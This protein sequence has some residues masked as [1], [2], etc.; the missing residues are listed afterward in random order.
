MENLCCLHSDHYPIL[1]HCDGVK[2]PEVSGLLDS[3]LL[4]LLIHNIKE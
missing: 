3:K 1:L 4:G 2:D